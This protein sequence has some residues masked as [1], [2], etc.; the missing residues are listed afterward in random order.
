MKENDFY[1]GNSSPRNHSFCSID[2]I[3]NT[4]FNLSTP[5]IFKSPLKK[6][7]KFS[8][9]ESG[10]FHIRQLNN[11]L[12]SGK[13]A[14]ENWDKKDHTKLVFRLLTL[15][16]QNY[17]I[18]KKNLTR[19]NAFGRAIL[20]E[21]EASKNRLFAEFFLTKI[22]SDG[23]IVLPHFTLKMDQDKIHHLNF[24]LNNEFLIAMRFIK[25][26]NFEF[27]HPETEAI[28]LPSNNIIEDL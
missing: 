25:F 5:K 24:P 27:W 10:Q 17:P 7:S 26:A 3:T 9:H 28:I 21:G 8:Y 4:G 14:V 22:P 16:F 23:N 20:L 13:Y 6:T 12:Y 11:N 18:D 2:K 15:P 1:W 19:D